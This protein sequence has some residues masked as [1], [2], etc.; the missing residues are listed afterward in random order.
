M[1]TLPLPAMLLTT[2]AD[3]LRAERVLAANKRMLDNATCPSE[4]AQRERFVLAASNKLDKVM[5]DF[6]NSK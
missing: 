5:L 4:R 3:V 1:S 2:T 6:F